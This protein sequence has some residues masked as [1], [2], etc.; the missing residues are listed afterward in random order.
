M[1]LEVTVIIALAVT[2]AIF[3]TVAARARARQRRL[4]R[5]FG[6]EH[7]RLV[8][9]RHILKS[10][11]MLPVPG[12]RHVTVR[13][14]DPV[15]RSRFAVRW[16]FTLDKFTYDPTAAIADA[17]RLVLSVLRELGYPTMQ[18]DE[19]ISGIS[20]DRP[21]LLDHFRST[22]DISDRSA[23]GLASAYDISQ[24]LTDYSTLFA[25]LLAPPASPHRQA[26]RVETISAQRTRGMKLAER[27]S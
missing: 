25:E 21:N 18:R 24:A 2:M 19:V 6:A 14:L 3:A 23:A 12:E 11:D 26:A 8:D 17:Q 27:G 10:A 15:F 7:E 9:E 5:C 20:A 16:G 4:R 22:C 1:S 13:P